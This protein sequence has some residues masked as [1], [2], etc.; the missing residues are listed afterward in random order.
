MIRTIILYLT[1]NEIT[2][3]SPPENNFCILVVHDHDGETTTDPRRE[4][5]RAIFVAHTVHIN[6]II[7]I[8]VQGNVKL[9]SHKCSYQ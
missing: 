3:N 1:K 2:R 5:S 9:S 6:I 8:N 4:P 7:V